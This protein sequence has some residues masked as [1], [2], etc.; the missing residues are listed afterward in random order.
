[1][2]GTLY[3]DD[4]FAAPGSPA[5]LPHPV[6]AAVYLVGSPQVGSG[7]Y[8]AQWTGGSGGPMTFALPYVVL[9]GGLNASGET[10]HCFRLAV[11]AHGDGAF[12]QGDVVWGF[13]KDGTDPAGTYYSTEPRGGLGDTVQVS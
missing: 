8:A 5:A 4:L 1:M 3:T 13:Y 2:T 11:Y 12:D 6:D 9:D 7:A 10:G